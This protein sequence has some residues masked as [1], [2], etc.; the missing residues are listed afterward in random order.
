MS[1]NRTIKD[2]VEGCMLVDQETAKSA[3]E[4]F[5]SLL[6]TAYGNFIQNSHGAFVEEHVEAFRPLTAEVLD[7]DVMLVK[8]CEF[9]DP[10]T[11]TF[12]DENASLV[13]DH[14]RVPCFIELG[15]YEQNA[16]RIYYNVRDQYFVGLCVE[17]ENTTSPFDKSEAVF[18]QAL[19]LKSVMNITGFTSFWSLTATSVETLQNRPVVHIPLH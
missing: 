7:M 1:K 19:P 12:E 18:A 16:V 2:L 11:F 8:D 4:D 17:Y 6:M 9:I 3:S 10:M 5:A 14:S 15:R 13:I